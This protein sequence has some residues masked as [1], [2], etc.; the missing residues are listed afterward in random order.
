MSSDTTHDTYTALPSADS[1]RTIA[2]SVKIAI[3]ATFVSHPLDQM[4]QAELLKTGMLAQRLRPR[5]FR[6]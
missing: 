1:D 4:L 3:L 6:T 2:A 5:F